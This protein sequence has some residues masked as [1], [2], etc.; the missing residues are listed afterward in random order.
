VVS[1]AGGHPATGGPTAT[2][3][4][5]ATGPTAASGA[6][7]T[8]SAGTTDA[9]ATEPTA[10]EPTATEPTATEPTATEPTATEPTATTGATAT[11]PTATTGAT[12]T[13]ATGPDG[14]AAPPLPPAGVTLLAPR[15]RRHRRRAFQGNA[16]WLS[17]AGGS[18]AGDEAAP[19]MRRMLGVMTWSAVLT[20][21]GVAVGTRAFMAML[22]LPG[23][24]SWFQ[25]AVVGA[26]A[27]G[28]LCTA[29]AFTVVQH[30]RLPW[31]L[32]PAATVA[33]CLVLMLTVIVL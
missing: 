29:A 5:T 33:L 9:T 15:E 12:A 7:A 11:G 2:G 27:V 28:V 3:G 8:G 32:L 31:L 4:A 19:R 17:T 13:G 1:T 26:G 10:T 23:V 24:P 21:V 25:P 6:T 20:L 22:F 16:T 30:R 18:F 14:A